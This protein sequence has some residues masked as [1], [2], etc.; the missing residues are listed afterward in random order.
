MMGRSG[1]KLKYKKVRKP[2]GYG[3][4]ASSRIKKFGLPDISLSESFHLTKALFSFLIIKF[5]FQTWLKCFNL[6]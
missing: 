6:H 5:L 4:K 3:I 1:R 2:W